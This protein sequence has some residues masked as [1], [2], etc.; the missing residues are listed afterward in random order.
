[1]HVCVCVCTAQ[2]RGLNKGERQLRKQESISPAS[3]SSPVYLMMHWFHPA[4]P[5]CCCLTSTLHS[6]LRN[7]PSCNSIS[8]LPLPIVYFMDPL[9]SIKSCCFCQPLTVLCVCHSGLVK[10]KKNTH[11]QTHIHSNTPSS[12][13]WEFPVVKLFHLDGNFLSLPCLN[14][15]IC[16]SRRNQ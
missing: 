5:H 14:W 8:L 9:W 16:L 10:D 4:I 6:L 7:S 13:S 2:S 3:E 1:M 11:T 15:H 12:P